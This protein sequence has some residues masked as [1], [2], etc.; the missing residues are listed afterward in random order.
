MP[1][2][3]LA[4][5]HRLPTTTPPV[6]LTA[7]LTPTN[8]DA[9]ELHNPPIHSIARRLGRE[10]QVS[11]QQTTEAGNLN[12]QDNAQ[13]YRSPRI[14]V[15]CLAAY[16]SG[17]LHGAWIDADQDADAIMTDVQAM[18]ADSPIDNAEEWAI[19][20]FEGFG[21]L[22]LDESEDLENVSRLAAFVKEHGRKG[23]AL[24][25]HYSGNIDEAEQAL[26]NCH[27]TYASLADYT[28]EMMEHLEVPDAIAPYVDY[29]RMGEDWETNG[30]IFTIELGHDEV[31]VFS[32]R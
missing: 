8:G 23:E 6:V 25:S 32:N 9:G 19:H 31:L 1:L 14:Y 26:E 4:E 11:N 5:P 17:T 18:L 20:D 16:N 28:E 30:D 24:L 7:A 10:T 29:Q 15:A 21:Q 22:R 3:E 2:R 13:A 12:L 27:G